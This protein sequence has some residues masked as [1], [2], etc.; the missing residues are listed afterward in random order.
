MRV[1]P[2]LGV[3]GVFSRGS[4]ERLLSRVP[5]R[6]TKACYKGFF[7]FVEGAEFCFKVWS[8][9]RVLREKAEDTSSSSINGFR[10]SGLEGFPPKSQK[11]FR[12][13][14]SSEDDP[15]RQAKEPPD[16]RTL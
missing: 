9:G 4:L 16:P 6:V 10:G 1:D 11:G 15:P 13:P 7:M 5:F 3:L 14:V 12:L 2:A 8:L